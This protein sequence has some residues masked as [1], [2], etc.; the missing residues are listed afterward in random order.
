MSRFNVYVITLI[1]VMEINRKKTLHVGKENNCEHFNKKD[2]D[3]LAKDRL[4]AL[5]RHHEL[6][7]VGVADKGERLERGELKELRMLR[8]SKEVR[9]VAKS[10]VEKKTDLKP[11]VEPISITQ[12][13]CQVYGSGVVAQS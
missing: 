7:I 6:A 9:G 12:Q 13:Y 1:F 2:S 3:T 10:L 8:N 5:K 4:L 11:L